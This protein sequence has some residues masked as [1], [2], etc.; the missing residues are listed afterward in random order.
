MR[1]PIY[2]ITFQRSIKPSRLPNKIHNINHLRS[3]TAHHN[4]NMSCELLTELC[5]A[6]RLTFGEAMSDLNIENTNIKT[7]SGVTIDDTQKTLIGSV[8]DVLSPSPTL[9]TN[10]R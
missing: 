6:S 5:F 9:L 10:R 4:S 3:L 2:P 8:L 1:L 7:A